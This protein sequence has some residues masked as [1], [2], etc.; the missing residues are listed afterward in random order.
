[1]LLGENLGKLFGT[2]VYITVMRDVDY[3]ISFLIAGAT[4]TAFGIITPCLIVEPPDL[5]KKR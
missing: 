2:G 4:I 1:M 5:V 3:K